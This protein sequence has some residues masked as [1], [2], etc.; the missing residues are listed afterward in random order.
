MGWVGGG[1]LM[2][3]IEEGANHSIERAGWTEDES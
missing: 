2:G 3:R 1:T